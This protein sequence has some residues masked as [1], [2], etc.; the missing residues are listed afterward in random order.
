MII[1]EQ[2]IN[3]AEQDIEQWLW[4]NPG[5]VTGEFGTIQRWIKRQY[6]VPSGVVDLIGLSDDY[7]VVVVEVKNVGIDAGAL[8]QVCRYAADVKYIYEWVSAYGSRNID[9]NITFWE[10]AKIVIGRSVDA[11]TL[12]EAEALGVE[13]IFFCVSLS[14]SLGKL[15]LRDDFLEDRYRQRRNLSQDV[16]WSAAVDEY[17]EYWMQDQNHAEGAANA[18]LETAGVDHDG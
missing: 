12:L 2:K 6:K 13:V 18:L 14:L 11:R 17:I 4:E 10:V 8:T 7:Q 9:E 16:E 15:V 3:L 1:D 5:A